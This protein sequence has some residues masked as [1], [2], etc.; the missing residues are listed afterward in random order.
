MGVRAEAGVGG[1]GIDV[2]VGGAGVGVAVGG[3]VV[4]VGVAVGAGAQPNK[5]SP[6]KVMLK[7]YDPT[8]FTLYPIPTA[9]GLAWLPSRD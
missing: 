2:A 1:T 9:E 3:T 5:K 7:E 4:G 6:I 8:L